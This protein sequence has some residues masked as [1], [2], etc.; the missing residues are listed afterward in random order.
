VAI[1][2]ALGLY[3]Q[4]VL[5]RTERGTQGRALQQEVSAIP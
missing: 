3:P 4:L 5:E 2:I 1:V